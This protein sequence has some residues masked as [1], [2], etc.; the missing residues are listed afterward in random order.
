MTAPWELETPGAGNTPETDAA[1]EHLALELPPSL[2]HIVGKEPR[3]QVSF[4]GTDRGL[5]RTLGPGAI[6]SSTSP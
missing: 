4:W 1:V 3:Q 5:S 6:S 2:A